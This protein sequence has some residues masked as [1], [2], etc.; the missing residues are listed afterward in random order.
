M[1][2][3]I[4]T[5]TVMG[6]MLIGSYF[7]GATQTKTVTEIKTIEKVKTVEVI[8]ESYVNMEDVSSFTANGNSLQLNFND[9][10]GYYWEGKNNKNTI[11]L[12][13]ITYWELNEND[14]IELYLEDGTTVTMWE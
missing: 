6:A 4:I 12:N 10:T 9:G 3:R 5:I 2:N 1:K 8:P 13:D 11:N 14:N 7:L